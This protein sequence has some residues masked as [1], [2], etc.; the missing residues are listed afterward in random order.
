LTFDHDIHLYL[1]RHT[2][3]RALYGTPAQHRQH[4]GDLVQGQEDSA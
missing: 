1:R 2:V 4:L 3:N